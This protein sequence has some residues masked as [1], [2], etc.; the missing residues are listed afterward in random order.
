MD[1]SKHLIE[2]S[3]GW[4][5][6]QWEPLG[7]YQKI[8]AHFVRR[9]GNKSPQSPWLPG[10]LQTQQL[11]RAEPLWSP[12][13]L[14]GFAQ[15]PSVCAGRESHPSGSFPSSNWG[16]TGSEVTPSLAKACIPLQWSNN[17]FITHL[18]TDGFYSCWG[19]FYFFSSPCICTDVFWE[20]DSRKSLAEN[21]RCLL[22]LAGF[23][24]DS[25]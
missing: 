20:P 1:S 4:P 7:K 25:C 18:T 13:T 19:S 5:R 21:K 24:N 9:Q 14:S 23:Y 16:P 6:H 15:S 3:L 22:I 17:V 8:P 12:S 2:M 10:L 11:L